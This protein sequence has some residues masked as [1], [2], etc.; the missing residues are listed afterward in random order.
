MGL[1]STAT[2]ANRVTERALTVTYSKPRIAGSWSWTNALNEV[3]WRTQ[4]YE[5]HRYASCSYRYVGMDYKSAKAAADAIRDAYTRNFK[6]SDWHGS[7]SLAGT[8][9]PLDMGTRLQG[10]VEVVR[11]RGHLYDVVVQI[12]EDDVRLSLNPY[13]SFA[14]LFADEDT[15]RYDY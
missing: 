3:Y 2:A 9:Q 6:T 14:G 11:D 15:R 10:S 12:D 5:Y 7:G 1:L 4:A 8:F 13:E